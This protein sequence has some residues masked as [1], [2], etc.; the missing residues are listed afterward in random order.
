MEMAAEVNRRHPFGSILFP[1]TF[2]ALVIQAQLLVN[3]AQNRN[4]HSKFT[5]PL[6]QVCCN[7]ATF[8][9][10]PSWWS[11]SSIFSIYCM[12]R[13]LKSWITIPQRQLRLNLYTKRGGRDIFAKFAKVWYFFHH[14]TRRTSTTILTKSINCPPFHKYVESSSIALYILQITFNW[15]VTFT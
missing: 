1:F 11:K 3:H 2:M 13:N 6:L 12:R 5:W 15:I 9:H 7:N 8:I 14:E 4:I 10:N